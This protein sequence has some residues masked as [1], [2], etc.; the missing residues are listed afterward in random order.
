MK[1]YHTKA[2]LLSGTSASEVNK[3]ARSYYNEIKSQTKR[4][5][6]VRSKYFDNQKVFIDYFWQHLHQ[7]NWHDRTRRLKFYQCA[8]ELVRF[9]RISPISKKNPNNQSEI[10]HRFA[11]VTLDGKEFFVQIKESKRTKQKYLLSVFPG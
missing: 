8:I 10:L 11:G 1:A 7:K 5:P 6:Y 2:S 9:S 4:R 3:Q